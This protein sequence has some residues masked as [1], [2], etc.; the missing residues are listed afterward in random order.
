MDRSVTQSK[1]ESR[2]STDHHLPHIIPPASS[3]SPKY[4]RFE[5]LAELKRKLAQSEKEILEIDAY[6]KELEQKLT[7]E[8]CGVN[9][10]TNDDRK[11]KFYTGS[12]SYKLFVLF[13]E[14]GKPSVQNMTS[15]HYCRVGDKRTLAGR[16][17]R[18]LLIDE[19][20]MFLMRLTQNFPEQDL[21]R[22]H[23]TES[24]VSRKLL[25]WTSL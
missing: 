8:K 17:R 19:F 3:H 22:F 6:L 11:V 16:P 2:E 5:Q 12:A 23:I 18:M 24:S 1:S 21:S 13:Y 20:F 7:I 4:D 14:S 15:A 10:F 25:T 9:R